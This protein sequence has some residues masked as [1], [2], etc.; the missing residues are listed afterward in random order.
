MM[1][2]KVDLVI[3]LVASLL[4][5]IH[6]HDVHSSEQPEKKALKIW[7]FLHHLSEY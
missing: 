3:P 5:V 1:I 7:I 6:R 4:V 2:M